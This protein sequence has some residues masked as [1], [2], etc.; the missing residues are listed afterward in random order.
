MCKLIERKNGQERKNRQGEEKMERKALY[1]QK[2]QR[3][4]KGGEKKM[5]KLIKHSKN[6]DIMKSKK[7]KEKENE[8]KLKI[9]TAYKYGTTEGIKATQGM[10]TPYEPKGQKQRKKTGGLKN[11]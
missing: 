3:K 5:E 7:S 9:P 4:R 11:A 6:F 1:F 2:E 10:E 8:L